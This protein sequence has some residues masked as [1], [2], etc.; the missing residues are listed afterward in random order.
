MKA[1]WL[2]E[3]LTIKPETAEERAALGA[4]QAALAVDDDS[5]LVRV[6]HEVSAGPSTG[7]VDQ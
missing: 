3:A 5:H 1:F 6:D 4:L 7:L 2:N